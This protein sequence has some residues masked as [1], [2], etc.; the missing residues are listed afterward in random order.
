MATKTQFKRWMRE[1]WREE[2][3]RC[4]DGALPSPILH[5]MH[6]KK[7]DWAGLQWLDTKTGKHHIAIN[8]FFV[9]SKKML[10][11]VFVHEMIHQLQLLQKSE[12]TKREHHGRFFVRHAFRIIID[13]HI[14]IGKY[15]HGKS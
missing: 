6:S 15:F 12:R 11:P 2:N 9:T 4:F 10:R 1:I 5:V 8:T 3:V 13:H 14:L 7:L